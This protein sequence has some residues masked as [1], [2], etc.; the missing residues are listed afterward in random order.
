MCG[1]YDIQGREKIILENSVPNQTT[2]LQG[3]N[4]SLHQILHNYELNMIA[5]LAIYTTSQSSKLTPSTAHVAMEV[6]IH[7]Y[8]SF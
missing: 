4:S 8:I 2:S 5:S 7:H 6:L 3:V 1:G